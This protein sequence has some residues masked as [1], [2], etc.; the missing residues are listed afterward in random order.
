MYW[1]LVKP[2]NY[3]ADNNQHKKLVVTGSEPERP[4]TNLYY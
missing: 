1:P 2:L 4:K 3:A